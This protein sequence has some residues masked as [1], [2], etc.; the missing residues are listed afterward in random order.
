MADQLTLLEEEEEEETIDRAFGEENRNRL[1][2]QYFAE[3]SSTAITPSNAWEHVYRLLLWSDATTGLAHCY[4][5]DKCQPGKPWY[6]RSLAF[7]DWI[8]GALHTTPQGLV[9][10]IDWLFIKECADLAKAVLKIEARLA[11]TAQA[12]LRPYDGR[13][14][15]KAGDDH[16]LVDLI[17]EMLGRYIAAEPPHDVW[18]L[19]SQKV[20]QYLAVQNKRNNLVGEGF[21]DVL[22]QVVRR[23]CNTQNLKLFT[24]C[25]LQQIPGFNL[26]K[27]GTKDNKVDLAIVRP[28]MRTLVTAKWSV[29]ADREKQFASDYTEYCN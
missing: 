15:P 18:H 12:Q 27:R 11:T 29:R 6:A 19:L 3:K 20:R 2:D 16:E 23:A 9:H 24:R 26:P 13:D 5:S 8:C 17:K 21:E 7:H 25:V 28:S 1:I 14:F 4:E 10:E 22:T